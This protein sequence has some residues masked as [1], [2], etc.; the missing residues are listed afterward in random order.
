MQGDPKGARV[1]LNG[2]RR[3]WLFGTPRLDH[4]TG[5]E[6]QRKEE[7]SIVRAS[8]YLVVLRQDS[9]VLRNSLES[10]TSY[11]MVSAIGMPLLR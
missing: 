8:A 4:N 5:E 6:E 7:A 3:G 11:N 2:V 1:G 9:Q 10:S